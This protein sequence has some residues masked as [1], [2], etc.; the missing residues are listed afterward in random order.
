MIKKLNISCRDFINGVALGVAAGS[1]R[2]PIELFAQAAKSG[3]PYPPALT[4]LRGSHPGSF[5]VSHAMSW[6]G[7]T[8]PRPDSLTD[9]IYDLRWPPGYAYEYNDYADPPEFNRYIGPHLVDAAQIGR[10]SIANSEASACA[11]VNGAIDAAHRAVNEQIG[12]T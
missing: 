10:I 11:Y 6:G 8:W 7:A 5:E 3:S 1:A 4:G 12:T 9:D 2:S